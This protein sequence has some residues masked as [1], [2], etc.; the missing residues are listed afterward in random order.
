PRSPMSD[1]DDPAPVRI[2][3][4]DDHEMVRRGLRDLAEEFGG[5]EVV[6]EADRASVALEG[7]AR[8][9]PQVALLDIRLPGLDGVEL[10]REIRSENPNVRCLMFTSYADEA[11]MGNAI[12]AGASAY[13]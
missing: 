5:I 6:G 11:A 4:V 8:T 1:R 10:C 9:Q 7:I 3:V 13:L 2:F 12:M